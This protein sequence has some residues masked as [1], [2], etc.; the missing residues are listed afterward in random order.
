MSMRNQAIEKKP[1]IL[2]SNEENQES[3]GSISRSP[4]KEKS[5]SLIADDK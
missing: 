1:D 4:A 5:P 3:I 2:V